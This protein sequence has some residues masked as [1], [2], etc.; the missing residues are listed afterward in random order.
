MKV[1]VITGWFGDRE[2][3]EPDF[4]ANEEAAQARCFQLWA[5]R[6]SEHGP[7][8]ARGLHKF[9]VEEYEVIA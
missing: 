2:W 7:D 9:S 3:I 6:S 5:E 8:Y 4:Y 1:Y